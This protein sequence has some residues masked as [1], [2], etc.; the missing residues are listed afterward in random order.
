MNIE[1]E[2]NKSESKDVFISYRRKG[3]ATAARLLCD[4]LNQRNITTFFDK[5]SLGEGDFNT[6]I[7]SGLSA[8]K[9]FILIVSPELFERGKNKDGQ[10]V[11]ELTEAD[12]VYREIKIA[13]ES[14]IPFIPIFVNGEA[15]FP[16][17]LPKEIEGVRNK[18]ALYLG[19]DHFEAELRKLIGRLQT[20]KHQ[21]IETYISITKGDA[22]KLLTF[23][24]NLGGEGKSLEI[25][26]LLSNM[27]RRFIDD[28][29][30]GS[31]EV[32]DTL[33]GLESITFVKGFC[34]RLGVDDT[35]DYQKIR[36]NLCAWLDNKVAENY[37][38]DESDQ[39]RFYKVVQ[40]FG[41]HYRDH[42][43]R[44]KALEIAEKLK[45]TI[46]TTKSSWDIYYDIFDEIGISNFFED[47]P[48]NF[49]ADDLKI[50]ASNLFGVQGGRKGDLIKSIIKYANYEFTPD[51]AE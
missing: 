43:S 12:W 9:N 32:I 47:Y 46:K 38:E 1:V 2:N 6:A 20:K 30:T 19:H 51:L 23:C 5:E 37:S 36:H 10:Y 49:P 14:K 22:V 8:A 45:V 17:L 24:Q 48:G 50:I 41:D 16:S 35:G 18:D 39:D 33:I 34:R 4:V 26:S 7:E 44:V 29:K 13:L 31:D 42:T 27:A 3:G 15:E 40:V 25:T 21:L 28:K 11:P